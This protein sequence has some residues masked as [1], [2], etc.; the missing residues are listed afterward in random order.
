MASK[1]APISPLKYDYNN[2]D[3]TTT[4]TIST[5][6]TVDAVRPKRQHS[7]WLNEQLYQSF[8]HTARLLGK[9]STS[10][11][12][13]EAMAEYIKTH[14]RQLPGDTTIN[15]IQPQQVN[16]TLTRRLQLKLVK[17]ELTLLIRTLERK[18]EGQ[19]FFLQKLK[20]LL[21]KALRL[22]E[23]TSDKDLEA[24]LKRTEQWV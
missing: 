4:S 3:S 15:I 21:P 16:I 24:L 12:L 14:S 7:F 23:K 9:L 5:I 8:K 17:R 2:N 6:S 20:E 1:K 11:A 19:G 10:Q 22:Y 18:P 13:Q